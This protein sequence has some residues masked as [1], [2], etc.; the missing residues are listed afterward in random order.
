MAG[1][2]GHAPRHWG[3]EEA[4]WQLC[5]IDRTLGAAI[6]DSTHLDMIAKGLGDALRKARGGTAVFRA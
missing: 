6:W 4:A 3:I 1:R 2:V 5:G